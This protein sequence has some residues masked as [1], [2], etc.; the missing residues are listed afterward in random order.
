MVTP[1]KPTFHVVPTTEDDYDQL[2]EWT[3]TILCRGDPVMDRI[4]PYP[5]RASE[6]I[7]RTLEAFMDPS[8]KTF[9]AIL[10]GSKGE[11]DRMVGYV[12]VV[13]QGENWVEEEIAE[14]AR[15]GEQWVSVRP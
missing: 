14:G 5:E 13:M 2:V 12:H 11:S 6:D 4:F 10:T 15:N 7:S 9:K 8:C 3:H 1:N